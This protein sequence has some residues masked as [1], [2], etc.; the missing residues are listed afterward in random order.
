MIAALST[1]RAPAPA[2]RDDVAVADAPVGLVVAP[3][4]PLPPE[5]FDPLDP[6]EPPPIPPTLSPARAFDSVSWAC[7]SAACLV[8]TACVSAWVSSDASVPLGLDRL[9]DLDVDRCDHPAHR[10]GHRRLRHR[11]DRRDPVPHR[12]DAPGRR[13]V[14]VR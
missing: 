6:L 9:A 7:A 13:P 4:D 10:E 2:L 5:P 3:P 8:W 12:V 1:M 14:A 11:F